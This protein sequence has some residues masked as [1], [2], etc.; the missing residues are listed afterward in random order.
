MSAP[1]ASSSSPLVSYAQE[2]DYTRT[3]GFKQFK[4]KY[5]VKNTRSAHNDPNAAYL[6]AK[7]IYQAVKGPGCT[8]RSLDSL[9]LD[10]F[11][12]SGAIAACRCLKR[13]SLAPYYV[14]QM[15]RCTQKWDRRDDQGSSS[16]AI[17]VSHQLIGIVGTEIYHSM[18]DVQF[19]VR[20]NCGSDFCYP[21]INLRR[22]MM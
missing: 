2:V 4:V 22:L 9:S 11:I 7:I 15:K 10:N 5:N 6:S 1:G 18:A 12:S 14:A 20:S 8:L 3:E 21:L 16:E 13:L 19:M 17:N